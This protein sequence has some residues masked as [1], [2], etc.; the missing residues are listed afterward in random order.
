MSGAGTRRAVV[1]GGGVGGASAA[2][3]L[4]DA[5]FSVVLLEQSDHLGGLVMSLEI[6]GT[7]IE[8]FYHHIF[9]H[10][11]EIISLIDA[12][13]LT[14]KLEWIRSSVAMLLGGRVWPFVSPGD[15]LR[16]GALGIGDRVHT[17]I[18]GLRSMRWKDWAALDRVTAQDWLAD[19]TGRRGY[20]VVW[21]PLLRAK[22]GSA[23][24]R[25]PA[26]WMWGRFQQ[27]SAARKTG[28]EKLGYLRGGFRQIFDALEVELPRRGVKV[29]LGTA[30]TGI[31]TAG[32]RVTG[33]DS[34][35]GPIEADTVIY[36]GTLPGL[37]PLVVP[38]ER[39]PRWEAIGSMGA[40]AVVVELRRR[41]TD[42]YW[43]NVVDDD[44]PLTAYIE[45]TN[46]V[47]ASDYGGVH[48][49]YLARY[50][51]ADDP[52]A[53][54]D[55]EAE[56]WRWVDALA[57]GGLPGFRR[58]DVIAIHPARTLY[59]APL[60]EVGH[61]GRIPPVR[62]HLAGLYVATTAQIYPQ[63]RGMS[64]GIRLGAEAA[65]HAVADAGITR[66]RR[67]GWACPVCGGVLY[68]ERYP[69]PR[70]GTEG[71]VRA[72]AFRPSSA[73]F[74]A[75][76]AA[77]V[78]CR[79]CGH[80]TLDTYPPPPAVADAYTDAVDVV[81]LRE[82]AGQIATASRA[83][84]RIEAIAAPGR[85]ADIGC[86]TG[87]L[88]VAAQQRGW[89]VAGV[90]PSAWASARARARGLEVRTLGLGDH[91]WAR[92]SF[93]AVA[94]CDVL[95]HLDDPAHAIEEAHAL[96]EPGGV[97]YLTVPDAGSIAARVMGR[98]WW[99][100]LPMHLQY[101]T[102]G[103]MLRLLNARGF[104]VVSARTHAKVF[105]TRYYAERLAGYAPPLAAAGV[106]VLQRAGLAD[107]LIAPN[108]GDRLEVIAV[109]R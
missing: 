9:P 97:L 94:M 45:H 35:A 98:R 96:L 39:D 101:F 29:Q 36:A 20:Q 78:T 43:V 86:W 14:P 77:I 64:E 104:R 3:R 57:D 102:R 100:V 37:A 8:R 25:V 38:S 49:A 91:G 89:D 19:L 79:A 22:F 59:A 109:S 69:I 95:E 27:R 84:E 44:L 106:R 93:R 16:F 51:T 34:D 65:S 75:A 12:M 18:G 15:L 7:P 82:E 47:P 17:G 1:I 71:G 28:V 11:H 10:E 60:V 56:G 68:R 85:L 4:A 73:H 81:S 24:D 74:G 23:A 87:S 41:I 31:R 2:L 108:L 107:K 99:S 6:G 67:S 42:T 33:V 30:A 88:L 92:G 40:M 52:L 70:D 103:S 26:A 55:V 61:L 53:T 76:L 83:L 62:A 32:G 90:E 50:F 72:D 48:I 80:G 21:E 63:D 46:F 5:G 66:P 54:A 58:E 13:G 105:T